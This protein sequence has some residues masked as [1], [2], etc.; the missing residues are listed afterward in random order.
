M[1]SARVM[2]IAKLKEKAK[3]FL[4]LKAKDLRL[5]RAMDLPKMTARGW[6]S[7]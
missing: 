1:R 3:D 5:A 4:N 6:R 7:D 2:A